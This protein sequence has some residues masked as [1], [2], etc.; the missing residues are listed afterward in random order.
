[1]KIR[2]IL[3]GLCG[4]L[5]LGSCGGP[6]GQANEAKATAATCDLALEERFTDEQEIDGQKKRVV[7]VFVNNYED[8]C[9]NKLQAEAQKTQP[10]PGV[11]TEVYYFD[12][13][14]HC[15][16]LDAKKID[17]PADYQQHCVA[18]LA[19]GPDGGAQFSPRPF[20]AQ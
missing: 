20:A 14:G 10:T 1:M 8:A 5:L 13:P 6:A 18:R 17:L 11:A 4:A 19:I 2:L 12:C 9:L 16:K 3:S 15:P 7:S